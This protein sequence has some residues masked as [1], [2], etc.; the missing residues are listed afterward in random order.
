[1]NSATYLAAVKGIVDINQKNQIILI[2]NNIYLVIIKLLI[3]Y[4]NNFNTILNLNT[5]IYLNSLSSNS[6]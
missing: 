1:M 2:K 3:L 4:L 6:I 5:I